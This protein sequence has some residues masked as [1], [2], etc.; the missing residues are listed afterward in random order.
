MNGA[1]RVTQVW[2]F[3][4]GVRKMASCCPMSKAVKRRTWT[5]RHF[6]YRLLGSD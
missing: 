2:I 3:R 5:A 6:R 4:P 1:R